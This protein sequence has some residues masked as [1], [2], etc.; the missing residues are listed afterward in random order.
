V[1][2]TSLSGGLATIRQRHVH[3][4][5]NDDKIITRVILETMQPMDVKKDGPEDRRSYQ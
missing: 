3:V 4:F 5:D 1:A 2:V